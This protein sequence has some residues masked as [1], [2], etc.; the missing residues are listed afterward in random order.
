[1]AGREP[2]T[3]QR[4][5]ERRTARCSLR[6]GRRREAVEER[7][8]EEVHGSEWHERASKEEERE[9]APS[10]GD[11]SVARVVLGE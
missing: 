3:F 4:R 2:L 7:S 9:E 8:E 5:L 1:M 11:A 6:R 10:E